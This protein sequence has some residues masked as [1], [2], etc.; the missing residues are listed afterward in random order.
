MS[1][2]LLRSGRSTHSF[3]EIKEGLQEGDVVALDAYQR[4]I[5]DFADVEEEAQQSPRTQSRTTWATSVMSSLLGR[6][7]AI[8]WTSIRGVLMHKLRSLLTVL[9]LVFGVASVIVM[10]AVA[11][12]AS[13]QAQKQIEA[14][15]VNNIILRSKKPSSSDSDINYRSFEQN[16]G[17]T[18]SDLRRIEETL[19]SVTSVTPL[20]EFRQE[21][22]YG[23]QVDRCADG[24]SLSQLL[25]GEQDRDCARSAYRTG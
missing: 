25:R 6:Y 2:N 18:Y 11:E 24:W 12:G 16:F 5:K 3:V 19:T 17:L 22:R 8:F 7:R 13:Q 20:R 14:L 21:A 23:A 10:L 1:E 4:G 15:G 9:G